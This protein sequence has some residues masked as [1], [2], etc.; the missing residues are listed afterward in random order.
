MFEAHSVRVAR[1]VPVSFKKWIVVSAI[2]GYAA[3]A[4]YLLYFVG[5]FNLVAAVEKVNF[6]IY[7]FAIGAVIVSI[8]FHTLV[9]FKLL[10]YVGIKTGLPQNI[11]ALLAWNFC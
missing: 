2:I 8:T 7:L 6:G 5:F 11:R 3:L 4:I 10:N 9:W 1:V